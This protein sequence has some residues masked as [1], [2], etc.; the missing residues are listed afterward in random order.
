M[1][2]IHC[3]FGE[4]ML[5]ENYVIGI[6]NEGVVFSKKEHEVL[7]EICSEQYKNSPFGYIS[8]R[9]HS[10]TIDPMIYMNM[11]THDNFIAIAVVCN[12][13]KMIEQI[14]KIEELFFDKHFEHFDN[15]NTAQEWVSMLVVFQKEVSEI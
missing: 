14:S 8:N 11:S 7:M 6:I 13:N 15:L 10:Y 3:D 4:F 1:R 9:I 5:Y 12:N 2:I